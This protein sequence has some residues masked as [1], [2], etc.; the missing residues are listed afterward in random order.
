MRP[1]IRDGSS[2]TSIRPSSSKFRPPS[3]ISSNSKSGSTKQRVLSGSNRRRIESTIVDSPINTSIAQNGQNSNSVIHDLETKLENA[4]K[5]SAQFKDKIT[6]QL[7]RHSAI[8]KELVERYEFALHERDRQI[9]EYAKLIPQLQ[10]E[11]LQASCFIRERDEHEQ[12]LRNLQKQFTEVET[13]HQKEL[14]NL[15]FEAI[16]RKIKLFAMEKVMREQFQNVVEQRLQKL[17]EERH[18]TLIEQ[19]ATL[20]KEKIDMTRDMER[21][22]SMTSTMGGELTTLQRSM[23]LHRNVHEEVL[24]HSVVRIRQ[25]RGKDSKL[26]RLEFKLRE[27]KAELEEIHTK[28]SHQYEGRIRGLEEEL[29]ATQNTLKTHRTELQHVRQYAARVVE[30]RSDLETFFYKVL[31]DCRRY[32]TGMHAT[33]SAEKSRHSASRDPGRGPGK[34]GRP[35]PQTND[36]SRLPFSTP[37]SQIAGRPAPSPARSTPFRMVSSTRAEDSTKMFG[38]TVLPEL[39]RISPDCTTLRLSSVGDS[40]HGADKVEGSPPASTGDPSPP[41]MGAY[42]EEMTWHDKEKVI[43]ALLF[44]INSNLNSSHSQRVS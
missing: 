23:E 3:S 24:K 7:E 15:K 26:Q 18:K 34:A 19:N 20:Q 21:L 6:Q 44:Y 25:Q 42:I 31:A 9:D 1:S 28:L 11:V 33:L 14:F 12:E 27:Q 2:R 22:L 39:S 30:Q 41:S 8:E 43:K 37:S 35:T 40:V 16:D 32:Q 38:M 36:G 13:R 4:L 10:S 5:E 17:T 29:K